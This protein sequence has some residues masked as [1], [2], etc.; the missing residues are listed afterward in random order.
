MSNAASAC[1]RRVEGHNA[2]VLET[3]PPGVAELPVRLVYRGARPRWL[4]AFITEP[5]EHSNTSSGFL[6][7]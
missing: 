2:A 5:R 7:S 3:L 4:A 1:E 6:A